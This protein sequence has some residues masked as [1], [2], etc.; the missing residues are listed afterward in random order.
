[1]VTGI[2]L[3]GNSYRN[4]IFANTY[5]NSIDV[6]GLELSEGIAV[7]ESHRQELDSHEF[8]LS[9]D[10]I[11]LASSS[12]QLG[13]TTDFTQAIDEVYTDQHKNNPIITA[14]SALTAYIQKNEYVAPKKY[15]ETKL[16]EFLAQFNQ[17]VEL[18]GKNPSVEQKVSGSEKSIIV[19]PGKP[20]R[21]LN[22]QQTSQKIL[23]AIQENKHAVTAEIASTSSVLSQEAIDATIAR[24]RIFVGKKVTLA[25]ED[26]KFYL[27]DQ[28]FVS[29][30]NPLGNYFDE[31]I[32]EFVAEISEEV[33]RPAQNAVFKYD[34]NTLRV[35]EFTPHK[36]GLELD[37]NASV[38]QIMDW[39]ENI[40]T[41]TSIKGIT[42]SGTQFTDTPQMLE[43]P[44]NRTQPEI[45]LAQ[46]ND[47]GINERIGFGESYYYHSIPNRIHN[48]GITAKK[49]NMTIVPPGKEFSF[50]KILGDVSAATGYRPAYVISGGKTVL[51]DGGGVCQVSSTTFRAALDA[52]L[53]ITKR[54]QHAYRVSY[55]ELNSDPGFD[56]TVYSGD[57]DFRFI[58]D[59]PNHIILVY[60]NDSDELY[61]NVEIYG[62]DDGRVAEIHDYKKWGATGPL[63]TEYY[64][65]TELPTGVK[66]QIDWA[67]GGI[68]TEFTHTVKDKNGNIIHNDTYYSNYRPWSAKYMVGI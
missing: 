14:F 8:V 28:D 26:K 30:L 12:A 59:T 49:M 34:S 35:D 6:S 1:M 3:L 18:V 33:N 65:T 62:T 9:V 61:M 17:K 45:T 42:S 24:A 68:K 5:I 16:A 58:N 21:T 41:E 11:S 19:F 10:N 13:Y 38:T 39:V 53:D 51:G 46:T 67:V 52:G 54:L 44:L 22:S 60:N 48:V 50:N 64:P 27:S 29:F 32:K 31:V 56:A 20:G 66:K 4:R 15:D 57:I 2:F 36:D 25:A 55:Y 23:D 63:P 40:E 43:V 47:L 37:Q 7:L